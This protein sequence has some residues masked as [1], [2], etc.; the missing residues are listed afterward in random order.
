MREMRGRSRIDVL[1]KEEVE[2]YWAC[3]K[4]KEGACSKNRE[5]EVY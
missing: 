1:E 3:S 5:G 4:N 2:V